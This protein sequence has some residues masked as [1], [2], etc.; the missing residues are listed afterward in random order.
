[1]S[2]AE[3][4]WPMSVGVASP[5]P[6]SRSPIDV[7]AERLLVPC[8]L[9]IAFFSFFLKFQNSLTQQFYKFQHTTTYHYFSTLDLRDW[10]F[11]EPT[12]QEMKL[13]R[14]EVCA[15]SHGYPKRAR[16]R[17]SSSVRGNLRAEHGTGEQADNLFL[18]FSNF[19]GY[20]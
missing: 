20:G 3:A 1:M 9:N 5:K 11:W 7:D 18:D 6:G 13:D 17:P 19:F 14:P 10:A 12:P 4:C 2:Q 15:R 8:F 16:Y